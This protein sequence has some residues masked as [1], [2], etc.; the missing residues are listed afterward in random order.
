MPATQGAPAL[1][2]ARVQQLDL[3]ASSQATSLS[4]PWTAVGPLQ[5]QTS[6]YGLITGRITAAAIDPSDTTGNTVYLGTSG[7]GVWKSTNA[8]QP[9]SAV[10]FQPLTDT[11][12]VYS[13]GAGTSVIPSLSIGAV[14]VQPGGTGVVLAGTGDPNDAADSYYGAGILRSADNGVTWSLIQNG[15]SPTGGVYSFVGQGIAGFA[16]S[17]VSPQLVVAAVSSSVE[18]AVVGDDAFPGV[19]GLYYSTD[20]GVTWNIATIQDGSTIVQNRFTSYVNFRGNAAT[21]VV[22]NPVRKRFYAAVR[23]HGYYESTDGMTWTRLANQPGSGLSTTNCPTRPGDYG[24]RNCPIFRGALAAQPTSGDLFALT[25]DA[26]NA[27]QGLWQDACARSGVACASPTVAWGSKLDVTPMEVAGAIVHGDYNLT[28]AAVPAATSLSVNDTLLFAGAGDLYRCSL[29][30][31]CTLRNTT[32]ATTGCGTPA[33]VAPAQHAIA[34]QTNFSNTATPLLY[35]G[36]DGGLWRSTDGVQQTGAACSAD[37]AS[38]FDNL[39]GALGSLAEV[40]SLSSHP[41]DSNTL[42]A[43]LGANGSAAST[44]SAQATNLAPWTQLS[45]GESG[46]VAIDQGNGSVWLAQSGAGVALHTCSNGVACTAVDFAGPAAVGSAQTSGDMALVDPPAL[47]DPVLNS[48]VITGTCRV[49]RGSTAGGTAWSVSNAISPFLA[50]PPEPACNSNDASIRSLAAGG[51][52]ALTGTAQTSGSPILY[53]GLSGVADGGSTFGGRI[54][55][56]TGANLPTAVWTDRTISPVTNDPAGFNPGQFD[57]SSISVDPNDATG[58][59]VYATI[60]GFGYP[61]VYRSTN[62]GA[63]WTN[64]SAN[65]PNAPA[66]ALA[67]DPNDARIVYV[68]METG[69]YVTTDVSSCI[70]PSG[71]TVNCWSVMGSS[72]PNAPVLSLVA[73]R[74][75][76]APGASAAGVLRA[77][78]FGRGIWQQPLLSAGTASVPVASFSPASL[79]FAATQQGTTSAPQ[80]LTLTNTGNAAMSISTVAA[81]TGFV[82]TDTCA[83]STLAVNAACTLQVYFAPV[84]QGAS[85]GTVQVFANVAGGYA[86]VALIGTGIGVSSVALSPSS[87]AFASTA[88]HATSAPQNITVSNNGSAAMALGSRATTGDFALATDTCGSSLA[89]GAACTLSVSFTPIASGPRSG[90]LSLTDANATH[91]IA[92]SGTGVAGVLSL[93]ATTVTFHDTDL[94]TT[95]SASIVTVSNTGTGT[96]N[97]AGVAATGDFAATSGCNSTALAPGRSCT[98]FITFTPTAVGTRTGMLTLVSD[99][100]GTTGT[101]T[102]VALTGN[103]RGAFSVVLTPTS[104]NFGNQLTGTTS[105][106]A[107]ITI[108]N[109]GKQSGAI[110][111]IA[112][113]GDYVL[114]A[115]TCGTSL[116]S[117]VGCTVSIVFAPSAGGTRNGLLTVVDDA[118][119]QTATLTGVG[120]AAATDTL[121]PLSLVFGTQQVNTAS[122]SQSVTLT[123]SGDA[124]LT[125]VSSQIL[126]GDF[127]TVN[128]CG[129][130]L[131]AHSACSIRVTFVPGTVGTRTGTLQV[132]DVQHIQTVALSGTAIAGPGVS[133]TPS[134]LTF[135]STGVGAVTAGQTLTLTNNGGVPLQVSAITVTGDFAIPVGSGTCSNTS[136]LAPGSSCMLQIVFAPTA[137]GA[138]TGT[139]SIQSNT[140]TQTTHLTGMAIDFSL[141][142]N[143]PTSLTIASGANAVYPLLLRPA[144]NTNDLV[145]YTCAGAPINAT[146]KVVSQY[147]DLSSTGTVTVT[148]LTGTS[149]TAKRI[150]AAMLL[151]LLLAC[152]WKRR[153]GVVVVAC[154]LLL[155]SVSC[156]T[157]RKSADS[158]DGT[159][160]GTGGNS[161]TPTGTYSIT[162]SATAAGITRTVPLTLVVQ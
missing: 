37:D 62:A 90:F 73:S 47:L 89:A 43:A 147:S 153:R 80:T 95:S 126:A 127:T 85:T 1:A 52:V 60:L 155:G 139:V 134:T 51:A 83:G 96:L 110:A 94:N 16:W 84:A 76:I 141:N 44:T 97:I 91:T 123:N 21:S 8:A 98:V 15:S 18:S 32:N 152:S 57:V 54:F 65:L 100:G 48:N 49:W 17:T 137:A 120:T 40:N 3:A 151:P 10:T 11:L 74:G 9:V 82:E 81:S 12:P 106:V 109:T 131:A 5:V 162:V 53:A 50:G 87:L 19:R 23:F 102:S 22:W 64:I 156:G 29:A 30:G 93:S 150:T 138:R 112:V 66:N 132:S 39:N 92:L 6:A 107:N 14:S 88:V 111:S 42:L 160:S 71:G 25:V 27:D 99:T 117:Q 145:T 119:T 72:L 157:G 124:P 116:A 104:F 36:N 78:T 77:G 46:T 61:H 35:F 133:L 115:N 34:W 75:I 58:Q 33:G 38:H 24:A 86:S 68:A 69:V 79:T 70:D 125:L 144:I 158:G 118:G 129:P 20:G 113:S 41:T 154:A 121:S 146:C 63:T 159:T 56:T 108:S 135:A 114:K 130:T 136:A 161:P 45:A 101:Q 7:G 26:H 4:V 2:A 55:V 59:T 31:G 128:G 13:P 143:G 67:V 105:A 122:A 140:T 103:G 148:V 149:A 28:L 142:A